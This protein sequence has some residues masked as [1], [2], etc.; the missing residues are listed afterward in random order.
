LVW[1]AEEAI[2]AG[3]ALSWFLSIARPNFVPTPVRGVEIFAPEIGT[4]EA[5][6]IQDLYDA[7][8]H[9]TASKGRVV[10]LSFQSSLVF[11]TA[12]KFKVRF[13]MSSIVL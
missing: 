11:S 9:A 1:G 10:V 3:V 6:L 12:D 2:A 5:P 8:D 4:D 13:V 7:G